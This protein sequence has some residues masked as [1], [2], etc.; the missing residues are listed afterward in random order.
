MNEEEESME[1]KENLLKELKK[2]TVE[3]VEIQKRIAEVL[4]CAENLLKDKQMTDIVAS[5]ELKAKVVELGRRRE[6]LVKIK[7]GV[8]RKRR[9]VLIEYKES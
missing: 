6:E 1:T 9:E 8:E 4:A 5:K 7:E 2:L 3:S